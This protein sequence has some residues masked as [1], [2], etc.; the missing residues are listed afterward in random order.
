MKKHTAPIYGLDD[1]GINL[2][3]L[4]SFGDRM[5]KLHVYFRYVKE[6]RLF[7][8]SPAERK[9]KIDEWYRN[10]FVAAQ[11]H[12]PSEQ[13][14]LLGTQHCPRGIRGSVIAAKVR[15]LRSI[16]QIADIWIETVPGL[17][18][19]KAPATNH[20]FAVQARFAIQ[21]E[22][23]KRGMQ[24]YE[25]RIVIVKAPTSDKARGKL[26]RGFKEYG[27][28]YLN[29]DG[30][31]VRWAFESVL[32][33]YELVADKIDPEGTEVFSVLSGRRLQ[34]KYKWLSKSVMAK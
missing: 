33:I 8:L 10:S 30:Y 6:A 13:F 12:W 15:A 7:P 21:V 3:T 18:R 25:D 19:K 22:E 9:A 24:G 32:D 28:P 5:I 34:P 31:M 26:Q 17:K 27:R 20:W 1:F 4:T 16:P 11:R 14:E 23:Q 2:R 29:S